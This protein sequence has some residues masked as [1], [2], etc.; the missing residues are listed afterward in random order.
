[1]QVNERSWKFVPFTL[2]ELNLALRTMGREHI[3]KHL[4]EDWSFKNPTRNY[5]WV[6]SEFLYWYI[7]PKGSSALKLEIPGDTAPHIFMRWPGGDIVDLTVQQFDCIV[8]YNEATRTSFRPAPGSGGPSKRSM[9]LA[10]LLGIDVDSWKG[11]KKHWWSTPV[12]PPVVDEVQLDKKRTIYVVR[13]DLV[14]GGTKQRFLGPM[15]RANRNIDTWVM[16]TSTY[17]YAQVA[18][19]VVCKEE[20]RELVIFY[21]KRKQIFEYTRKAAEAGAVIIPVNMGML[22]VCTARAK[23]Y[24]EEHPKSMMFPFGGNHPIVLE[25][26]KRIAQ[27]IASNPSEV[28]TA[29]SSGTLSRGLQLAWPNT[30]FYGVSVGH[31]PTEEQRGRATMFKA[32]EK[33][34]QKAKDP[35]PFP[36]C[37]FYDAKVWAIMKEHASDGALF[38]NVAA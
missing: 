28:W 22:T 5:C 23:E 3:M 29:L 2:R 27:G 17:G 8:D 14:P 11:R 36:S 12:Q 13:D 31:E 30:E 34:D 7:A 15:V 4:Q 21:P 9:L 16:P 6:V 38:W 37:A 10:E 32:S 35:P 20:N 24:I 19:S 1:M 26:I 25:H 18:M 33:F